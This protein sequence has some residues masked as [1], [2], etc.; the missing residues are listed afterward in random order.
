[1]RVYLGGWITGHGVGG[2]GA[3]GGA[4]QG[5]CGCILE[6]PYSYSREGVLGRWRGR[7]L[8]LPL[9]PGWGGEFG[10]TPLPLAT[11]M[12]WTPGDLP[13]RLLGVIPALPHWMGGMEDS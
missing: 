5:A 2:S 3:F 10:G 12:L 7:A 9:L 1:M 8:P 13:V 6:P 11:H 4:P